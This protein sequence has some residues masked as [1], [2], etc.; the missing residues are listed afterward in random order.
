VAQRQSPE[1]FG[2]GS[3]FW[4]TSEAI[5]AAELDSER[6]VL[7]NPA[8]ERLFG[9][10]PD[11]ALGMRLDT[12]VPDD[13][14][15]SHLAGVRRYREHGQAV[16]VGGG[17]VDVRAV[18]KDGESKDVALTLTDVSPD[19]AGRWVLAVIRDVSAQRRAERELEA[20]NV[21]MR[22]FVATASHD[23]RT[24]LASV[25]GFTALLR[26]EHFSDEQREQFLQTIERSATHASRL[27]D[28]LLTLS[29][30]HAGVVA[31]RSDRV[32]VAEVARRACAAVGSPASVAID[33]TLMV[34]G[35]PDHLERM[36]ANYLTNAERHGA[37]PIRVEAEM[38]GTSILIRVCDAG[39][40]VPEDFTERL[41]TSFT[42]VDPSRRDG[43]G[44][45]L[46]IVKG[47][48]EASGGRAFYEYNAQRGCCFGISLPAHQPSS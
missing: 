35:D 5:V 42:R 46:S 18:T 48:A 8:A 29:Q 3:L 30:I 20:A 16:L 38:E 27:V 7:W 45:G 25:L 15:N 28:D 19:A 14:R 4:L 24:P 31:A 11:E 13:L 39:P 10:S 40:G 26:R 21:A 34:A 6:I 2:I 22:E 43:T 36:L 1:D 17:P 12:L 23:L 44:L 41:F 9:Y 32:T 33:D 47:L 37:E